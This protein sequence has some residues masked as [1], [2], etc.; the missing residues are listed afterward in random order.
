MAAESLLKLAVHVSSGDQFGCSTA[1]DNMDFALIG[2]RNDTVRSGAVG[3]GVAYWMRLRSNTVNASAVLLQVLRAPDAVPGSQFGAAVAIKDGYM[4]VGAPL[5]LI[6]PFY[7]NSVSPVSPPGVWRVAGA[8][9]VWRYTTGPPSTYVRRLTSDAP[10]ADYR[11]G[12]AVAINARAQSP[13]L[14]V[15]RFHLTM[16]T[17][18]SSI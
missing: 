17:C 9:Y 15:V 8:A 3:A 10:T 4:V 18:T 5:Q 12:S 6:D 11:F 13:I 2:A 1:L 7:P 14:R 16:A